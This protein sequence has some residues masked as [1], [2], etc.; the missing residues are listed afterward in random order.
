MGMRRRDFFALAGSAAAG[1][2][3]AA[4]TQQLGQLAT[5]G[6]LGASTPSLQTQ[7][8]AAFVQ[9]LREL[10]WIEGRTVAIEFRWGEGDR[11]RYA[12]SIAEFLRLKVDI[13]VTH[14]SEAVL[15]A[16]QATSV[17]PIV[18]PVEPNPIE[19]GIVA[20]LAR[21]GGNVTGLSLQRA[22]TTAKRIEFLREIVPGLR[23]LALL[24]HS[25]SSGNMLEAGEV[26]DTAQKLGLEVAKFEI[27]RG[28]DIALAF[29]AFRDRVEA[30][31]IAAGP[32]IFVNRVRIS[33]LALGARLPTIYAVREYVDAG[34][35]ISYGPNFADLFRRSA[36]FVDKILR[37]AKPADL[38]V[39]QATKFELI[40]NLQAAKAM[41]LTIPPTLLARADEVIE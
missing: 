40:I 24:V 2:P 30:L 9:R 21:P 28:E 3:L 25:G 34:G 6:F 23:R 16:K 7:W 1:W 12:A 27:Q 33:T 15:M 36:E 18:F 20:S 17:L 39:E 11:A 14:G 4:R 22:D 26:Q 41:G 32:L 31:Y 13:I 10:G 29:E 37:G 38:P 19:N 8:T 5:I 35:L